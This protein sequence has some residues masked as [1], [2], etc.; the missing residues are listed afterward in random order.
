MTRTELE[1]IKKA[2]EVVCDITYKEIGTDQNGFPRYETVFVDKPLHHQVIYID[3][4]TNLAIL[5]DLDYVPPA[6]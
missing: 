4:V 1:A 2:D 6:S 3:P 5:K